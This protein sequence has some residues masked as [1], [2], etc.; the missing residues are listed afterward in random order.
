MCVILLDREVKKRQ[1]KERRVGEMD[2]YEDYNI[3]MQELK[4]TH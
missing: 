1:K 2:E 4:R 3:W